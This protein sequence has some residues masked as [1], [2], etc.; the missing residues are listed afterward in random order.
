MSGPENFQTAVG[1]IMGSRDERFLGLLCPRCAA[2]RMAATSSSGDE[3][4]YVET[5]SATAGR[6]RCVE[7]RMFP[8][9]LQAREVLGPRKLLGFMGQVLKMAERA[10][11]E[12]A[13]RA[14]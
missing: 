12:R 2:D 8:L 5:V 14:G 6:S 11:R 9:V 7:C 4:T 3:I 10:E 1:Y 13:P